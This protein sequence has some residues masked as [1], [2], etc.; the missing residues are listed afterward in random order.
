MNMQSKFYSISIA[1]LL[2]AGVITTAVI[3]GNET[4]KLGPLDSITL[5]GEK[6][7]TIKNADGHIAWGDDKTNKVWSIGFMEE[8][9]ALSHLL[10]TE[11]FLDKRNSLDDEL[12]TQISEARAQ[13]ETLQAEGNLLDP[14]SPDAPAFRQRWEAAYGEFQKL[15]KLVAEVRATLMAEQMEAAYIEL[16]EA[17]NVVSERMNIDMVFR[18]IPPDGEFEIAT[19]D[20]VIM[21]IRLRT[22]LR[23]PEGVDI[24]DDVLVELGLDPRN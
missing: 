17:V 8:G 12:K 20:A 2:L 13:M 1:M 24:T 16:L 23:I 22:A 5:A 3:G 7:L 21:Q 9:K 15:Q 18:F 19:P 4:G 10:Q 14:D 11:H 6:E